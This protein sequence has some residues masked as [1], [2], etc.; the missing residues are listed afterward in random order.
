F[1]EKEIGSRFHSGTFQDVC[2]LAHLAATAGGEPGRSSPPLWR[3]ASEGIRLRSAKPDSTGTTM[4]AGA[5]R[6]GETGLPRPV[7]HR[8]A[9][10]HSAL[11][12]LSTRL[13]MMPLSWV[14]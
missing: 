11:S 2:R 10:V 3:R 13:G 1:V 5:S 4:A 8:I 7:T 6:H 12:P 14:L 9:Q